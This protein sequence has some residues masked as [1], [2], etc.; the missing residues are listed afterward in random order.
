MP[1]T[2][3]PTIVA[4][5]VSLSHFSLL[6]W[7]QATTM[8]EKA[9][10]SSPLLE[11]DKVLEYG[12]VVPLCTWCAYPRTP[13]GRARHP[14]RHLVLLILSTVAAVYCTGVTVTL[15][16]TSVPWLSLTKYNETSVFTDSYTLGG[17]VITA[18]CPYPPASRAVC[19]TNLPSWSAPLSQYGPVDMAGTAAFVLPRAQA[20]I[21]F[22]VLVALV[23][24]AGLLPT[25]HNPYPGQ[26]GSSLKPLI[27][28][29]VL[30]EVVVVALTASSMQAFVDRVYAPLLLNS[31]VVASTGHA[32]QTLYPQ[33]AQVECVG[34]FIVAVAACGLMCGVA[35]LVLLALLCSPR[36][37]N[38]TIVEYYAEEDAKREDQAAGHAEL[39]L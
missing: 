12:A 2:N 1:L 27:L 28:L 35:V 25:T 4:H 16:F 24:T 8:G 34:G 21:A 37:A 33:Q 32:P 31:T 3:T 39:L 19:I 18:V 10:T 5:E 15:S 23:I 14:T 29:I 17:D 22:A 9:R 6:E 11:D 38:G 13:C 7:N 36:W 30:L 20:T 26:R